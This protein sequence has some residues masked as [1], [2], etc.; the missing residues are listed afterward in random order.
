LTPLITARR[1][2]VLRPLLRQDSSPA[3]LDHS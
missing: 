1:L 2:F 3:F